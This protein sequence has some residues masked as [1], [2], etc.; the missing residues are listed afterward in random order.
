MIEFQPVAVP[1]LG[2]GA[3]HAG[4]DGHVTFIDPPAP[5]PPLLPLP[6]S[7]P[8]APLPL[9]APD[10]VV[11]SVVD[12]PGPQAVTK[13][14]TTNEPKEEAYRCNIVLGCNDLGTKKSGIDSTRPRLPNSGYPSHTLR[15]SVLVVQQ[16]ALWPFSKGVH[17]N[18]N[19]RIHP[20]TSHVD[21][22]RATSWVCSDHK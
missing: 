2:S 11:D 10:T 6:P 22:P 12:V 4:I 16:R 13:N 1:G 5:P 14:N 7:P 8:L 15:D 19:R 18:S 17:P 9:E 20:I 21:S 3:L